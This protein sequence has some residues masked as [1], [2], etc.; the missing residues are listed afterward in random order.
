MSEEEG[1][2]PVDNPDAKPKKRKKRWAINLTE[3]RSSRGI[4]R[5]IAEGYDWVAISKGT[6]NRGNIFWSN[7]PEAAATRMTLKKPNQ[8]VA[9]IPSMQELC[10]KVPFA[11]MMA[12]VQKDEPDMFECWPK[13][14]ILPDEEIPEKEYE[15]PLIFKPSDTSQ[16]GGIHI[17]LTHRICN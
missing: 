2:E 17:V 14:W 16:G 6:S 15:A 1:R 10:K 9:R 3:T 13:T 4:V 8:R 5:Y 12:H 11:R 7:T